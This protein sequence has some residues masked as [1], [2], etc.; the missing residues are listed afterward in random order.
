VLAMPNMITRIIARFDRAGLYVWHCHIT[1][2][3][4]NEMMRPLEIVP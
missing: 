1:E 4:D 2:H 3:E